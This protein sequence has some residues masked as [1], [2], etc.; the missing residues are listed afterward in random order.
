MRNRMMKAALIGLALF[1]I[2]VS[3]FAQTA[4]KPPADGTAIPG[5][6]QLPSDSSIF[7]IGTFDNTVNQSQKQEKKDSLSYLVGG[8][9]L[10]DSTVQVPQGFSG[11]STVGSFS[12]KLFGKITVPQY[13][14]LYLSYDL[15]HSLFEGTG[16]SV[17]AGT[18]VTGSL[19]AVGGAATDL[20]ANQYALSEF[21]FDFDIAKT[22]FVR[23]GNQLVA[24]GPSFIWTPV[25]FINLQKSSSLQSLDLR[26]G[27]PGI[28]LFLPFSQADIT[29]FADLSQTVRNG[30]VGNLADTARIAARGAATLGGFELGLSGY[31]GQGIQGRYGFD[32]S[33]RVLGTDVYGELGAGF[34]Y[35]TYSFNYS[36]SLGFTRA[37]GELKRW[38]LQGEFFYNSAGTADAGSYPAMLAAGSFTPL[39]VGNVYGYASLS[40]DKFIADFLK[41]TISGLLNA[42]DLSYQASLKAAFSIPRL[43]PFAATLSFNGGGAGKELTYFSG[44]NALTLDLQVLV[45]F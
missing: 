43:V 27:K 11:Y 38:T 36:Y 1:Y 21:F 5:D 7:N 14:Q 24:W 40:K 37:L 2:G 30:T 15:S 20:F 12:G 33:G 18:G 31:L 10:F 39:Y 29:L 41:M 3:A 45:Q 44:N 19:G 6:S 42:S 34:A 25:D 35:D 26:V 13:G 17:P 23:I 32:F 9:L 4:A 8:T 16:G 28:K 22:L